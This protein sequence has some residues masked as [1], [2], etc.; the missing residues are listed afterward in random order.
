MKV[1]VAITFAGE[2]KVW[3]ELVFDDGDC[4][5][6]NI[7]EIFVDNYEFEVVN[8]ETGKEIPTCVEE[9]LK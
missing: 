5:W 8:S 3:K 2:T 6:D 4:Y 7:Y 9:A 1:N